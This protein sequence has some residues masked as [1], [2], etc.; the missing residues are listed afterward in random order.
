[1]CDIVD[2]RVGIAIDKRRQELRQL[3]KP[4]PDWRCDAQLALRHDA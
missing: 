4:K 2:A 3:K 1:V